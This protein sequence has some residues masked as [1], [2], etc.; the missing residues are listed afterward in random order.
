VVPN[1]YFVNH[2]Y[3]N[4]EFTN[5]DYQD[6]MYFIENVRPETGSVNYAALAPLTSSAVEFNP[7]SIG[8]DST[9]N[10]TI[11]HTGITH[12]DNSTDPPAVIKSVTLVGPN[13]DEFSLGGISSSNIPAQGTASLDVH[14]TPTSVGIKNAAILIS[15]NNSTSPLRI[16]LY[17]SGRSSVSMV[18]VVKRIKGGS[19]SNLN[20]GGVDYESDQPYR[21]GSVRL[22]SQVS[23]S[24]VA[25]TDLDQ[26]YQTYLSAAT[27]LAAT[28]Y[29]I[30]L[31]NGNYLVRMHFVENYFD[32]QPGQRVFSGTMEGQQI[33]SNLDIYNE[34]G[35]RTA[36]VKDFTTSV[37]DDVL[38]IN[39]TPTVNRL[40]IAAIEIFKITDTAMPVT[41][42]D[43]TA[44]KEGNTALL[45]WR[46]ADEVNSERF[47][48]QRS[49]TGKSWNAIG[50]VAAQGESVKPFNYSFV[51]AAPLDGENLYRLKMI[52]RDSTYAYS[53]LVNLRF[54]IES[55]A[56][57]YPNPVAEKLILKVDDQEKIAAV[58]IYNMLG[59]MV[60]ESKTAPVEGIDVK[61]LRSGIYVVHVNRTDGSRLTYKIVKN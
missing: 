60:M 41:L 47:E 25:G 13:A 58:R 4:V 22:D 14:F 18:S 5:Y 15:Y 19:D 16:P 33:F 3:I 6:N 36:I 11:S 38:N 21:T 7:V 48:I 56:S 24:D 50:S 12:P 26:L 52:D 54:N 53:K 32:G 34:V 10:F 51:D 29:N 57:L 8:G 37:V 59:T 28:G 44:A 17:G 31:P 1:A 20:I 42:I 39:F 2:D 30:P 23:Q 45:N 9:I 46:T 49:P 61:S 40:A 55:G 43:F 27:D 35:Y